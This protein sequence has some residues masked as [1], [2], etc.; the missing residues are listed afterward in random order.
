MNQQ[1]AILTHL[2]GLEVEAKFTRL[3]FRR[4]FSLS[5]FL[6]F[7]FNSLIRKEEE[8]RGILIPT[9]IGWQSCVSQLAGKFGGE[10]NFSRIAWLPSHSTGLAGLPAILSMKEWFDFYVKCRLKNLVFFA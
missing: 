9:F 6:F 2:G 1:S 3:H 7:S 5:I 10:T 4:P 8:G